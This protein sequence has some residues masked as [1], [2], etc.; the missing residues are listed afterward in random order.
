MKKQLSV[1]TLTYENGVFDY[2]TE[3]YGNFH[4]SVNE[5][6]VIRWSGMTPP[7]AQITEVDAW[8]TYSWHEAVLLHMKRLQ[9]II[10]TAQQLA[11]ELENCDCIG[12]EHV[13]DALYHAIAASATCY[14]VNLKTVRGIAARA[15]RA[16]EIASVT[17]PEP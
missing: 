6:G 11:D 10:A 3:L 8:V 17:T 7:A 1:G 12:A 9:N 4:G 13:S 16:T 2:N 14:S 15:R 5:I